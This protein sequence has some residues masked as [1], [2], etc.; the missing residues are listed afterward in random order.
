[1]FINNNYGGIN[2]ALDQNLLLKL[3]E[4][5]LDD[6]ELLVK[7]TFF[8]CKILMTSS[9]ASFLLTFE[10]GELTEINNS[11]TVVDEWDFAI[12]AA[13]E[14]WEKFLQPSPPPMFHD[15]WAAVWMGHMELEGNI[16]VFM[17]NHYALWR[18]LRL[19]REIQNEKIA[20]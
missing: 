12:K 4:R 6:P 1:M 8:S 10:N 11:P 13:E 20:G 19:L 16:K 14:S 17:Q 5:M 9:N 7:G 3:Q 15:V 2:L 18:T